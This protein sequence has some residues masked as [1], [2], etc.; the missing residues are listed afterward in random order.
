MVNFPL[1]SAKI[2]EKSMPHNF[3]LI[4]KNFDVRKDVERIN[5]LTMWNQ[6]FKQQI[7]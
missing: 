6:L 3:F 4:F 2:L 1:I 7:R 5:K